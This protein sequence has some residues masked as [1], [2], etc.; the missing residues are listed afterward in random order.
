[1]ETLE[2]MF[3]PRSVAV[4]G[5]SARET[6]FNY[7]I[8]KGLRESGFAGPVY[9]INPRLDELLGWPVYPSVTDIPGPLDLALVGVPAKVVLDVARQCGEVGAKAM[10]IFTGGFA[11][12]GD[13]GAELQRRLLELTRGYGM[14]FMGPNCFGLASVGS[15]LTYR[16][17]VPLAPGRGG[18]ICQ[19]G[20]M[21]WSQALLAAERGVYFDKTASIGNA[22]DLDATDFLAYMGQDERIDFITLYL[23]GVT[24]GRRF[25]AVLKETCR[26]KPVVLWKAGRSETGARAAASHTA[27]L[28]GE[29]H[30][31]RAAA[32]QAGALWCESLTEQIDLTVGVANIGVPAGDRIGV[33]SGPGAAGV[34]MADA[35]EEHGLKLA[36]LD[37]ETEERLK[38]FLP[39]FAT[40]RN[41]VDLTGAIFD[42][43]TLYTRSGAE[44]ARDG[45]V[46]VL[47]LPGPSEIEPELFARHVAA[48]AAGW[49]KPVAI[50]WIASD[51]AF[52]AGA[53]ILRNHQIA[54]FNEPTRAAWTIAKLLEYG[55]FRRARDLA[56]W[57][58]V[59]RV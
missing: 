59:A 9:P 4:V 3:Y 50:P 23:E 42:D 26:R 12:L 41:P 2:T 11:E 32:R 45:N 47:L 16:A 31:F 6:H 25:F 38:A 34:A 28:S 46:D 53:A 39:P 51:R 27:A 55:R 33:V 29:A 49:A 22:G 57:G 30:V 24:D 52:A 40:P 8:V 58:G 43:M 54:C 36:T 10:V 1:M 17:G 35:C 37:Q 5:A 7:G 18:L 13:E 20:S 15:K 56:P 48:E 44:V 21:A 14:R 19:S